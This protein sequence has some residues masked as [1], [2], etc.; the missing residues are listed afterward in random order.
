MRRGIPYTTETHH[1]SANLELLTQR[2]WHDELSKIDILTQQLLLR[3]VS[4][5]RQ[6]SY[7]NTTSLDLSPAGGLSWPDNYLY[8]QFC[9]WI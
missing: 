9:G 2:W 7:S 8:T 3:M 6:R 4:S 5:N 1:A